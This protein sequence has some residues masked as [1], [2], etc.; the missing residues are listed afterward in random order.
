MAITLGISDASV[1]RLRAGR[2]E[3]GHLRTFLG[4]QQQNDVGRCVGNDMAVGRSNIYPCF[5]QYT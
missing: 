5:A 1:R 4:D 3:S 2:E